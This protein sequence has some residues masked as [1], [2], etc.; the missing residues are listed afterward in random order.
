MTL[1][2]TVGFPDVALVGMGSPSSKVSAVQR[3]DAETL[4][5]TVT[6]FRLKSARDAASR[7]GYALALGALY[8][9]TGGMG[10]PQHLSTCLGVLFTLSQDSTSPEV[11]V[12]PVCSGQVKTST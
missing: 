12:G 11:Q 7:S 8:R 6:V 4:L 3:Y 9:Y 5:L 2:K 10:S 1:L